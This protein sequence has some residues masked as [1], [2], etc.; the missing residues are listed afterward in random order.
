M[1]FQTRKID[2]QYPE[3]VMLSIVFE[4]II[5]LEI[6]MVARNFISNVFAVLLKEGVSH[7][8]WK[9]RKFVEPFQ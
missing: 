3:S 2:I 4:T 5:V 6:T 7:T 8:I 9:T 1:K